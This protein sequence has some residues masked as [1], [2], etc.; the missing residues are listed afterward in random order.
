M[1]TNIQPKPNGPHLRGKNVAETC[2]LAT[3]QASFRRHEFYSGLVME[4]GKSCRDEEAQGKGTNRGDA[5]KPNNED[6]YEIGLSH[7]SDE[8]PVMRVERRG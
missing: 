7:S 1:K 6:L 8:A 5:C 4:Q 3:W 2:L